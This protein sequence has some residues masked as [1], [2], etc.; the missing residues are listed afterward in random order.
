MVVWGLLHACEAFA[1]H[2]RDSG[3]HVAMDNYFSSPIIMGCLATHLIFVVGTLQSNGAGV[4]GAPA[5]WTLKK[6][7]W[8]RRVLWHSCAGTTCLLHNGW[9][10]RRFSS[11][12]PSISSNLTQNHRK[13]VGQKNS[14]QF[15]KTIVDAWVALMSA[16]R[17]R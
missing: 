13:Y 14:L 16:T 17:K 1:V 15:G 3:V 5:T 6:Y 10:R 8:R 7:K 2:L 9:T 12:R 4:G 11:F